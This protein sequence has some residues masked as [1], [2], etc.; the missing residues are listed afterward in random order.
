MNVRYLEKMIKWMLIITCTYAGIVFNISCAVFEFQ[1]NDKYVQFSRWI[2][3]TGPIAILYHPVVNF[4]I[5]RVV[6]SYCVFMIWI[7]GYCALLRGILRG[8]A[9]VSLLWA[10]LIYL[11]VTLWFV[12]G[13][14]YCLDGY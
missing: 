8:R 1:A 9:I 7:C 12:F 3:V 4:T 14:F 11:W 2:G 10:V 6:V 13:G 5:K